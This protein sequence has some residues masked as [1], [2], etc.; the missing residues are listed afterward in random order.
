MITKLFTCTNVA[1]STEEESH[2]YLESIS[3]PRDLVCPIT[4]EL[5][6]HPVIAADGH[7]YE[8]GAIKTWFDSQKN[9]NGSIRSPVTNDYIDASGTA[10]TLVENKAIAGMS[11][12]YRDKLGEELCLRCQAI[13]DDVSDCLGDKGFRIKALVEAG[14]EL[15]IKK[16]RGG[17]T[18][19]MA[20]LQSSFNDE[21]DL[22]YDLLNY[23]MVHKTP[24]TLCNDER[25]GCVDLADEILSSKE[26]SIGVAYRHL[27]N[28]I[29]QQCDEETELIRV[30]S[31]ARD[32]E[33]NEHRERQR[34]LA[35]NAQNA[36]TE[37]NSEVVNADALGSMDE[38]WGHFPCMTALL[39]QGH[40]PEPPSTFAEDEKEVEKELTN[41]L[42]V[43]FF[44]ATSFWLLC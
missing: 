8:K 40:V 5:F 10:T 21:E 43:T 31:E 34:E 11:R 36:N 12:S 17:N 38:G 7:T 16:C 22:K 13:W 41:I 3:A 1:F 4:Q 35:N 20:L 24:V 39:F 42:K 37:Q 30:K 6:S 32:E 18:A 27:L 44:L 9:N 29:I 14:A 26:Q 15:S 2:D 19:F 25:K 33:N 28:Q 23:F